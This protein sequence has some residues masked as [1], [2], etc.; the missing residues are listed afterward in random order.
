MIDEYWNQ[1]KNDYNIDNNI[2][3]TSSFSFG[4]KADELAKLVVEGKKTATSSL[5]YNYQL[6]NESIPKEGQ[7]FIITNSEDEPVAI[8]KNIEIRITPFKNVSHDIAK[9]EGEGDLKKWKEDH[10]Q[11]FTNL[12]GEYELS[13]STDHK[14]ITEIFELL[15]SDDM[16]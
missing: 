5:L 15:Y 16:R 10:N 12:L 1:F 6:E 7:Y 3:Y 2:K 14:V 4:V 8:I 11:F 9:L 13:F